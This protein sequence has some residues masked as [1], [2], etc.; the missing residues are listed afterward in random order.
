MLKEFKL[1]NELSELG[2]K[3]LVDYN[4]DNYVV[5]L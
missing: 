2:F 1:N 3:L 4:D 5:A